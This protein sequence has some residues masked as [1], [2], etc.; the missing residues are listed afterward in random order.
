M[1][2]NPPPPAPMPNRIAEMLKDPELTNKQR[3]FVLAHLRY[4]NGSKAARVAGY[5]V[6]CAHQQA[7]E[8]MRKPK[9]RR[10]ID[11]GLELKYCVWAVD[12]AVIDYVGGNLINIS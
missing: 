10:I 1:V 4:L 12:P 11:K 9:I 5:S 6:R 8:N 7:Y 2:F 3:R